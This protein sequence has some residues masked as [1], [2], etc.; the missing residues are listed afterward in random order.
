MRKTLTNKANGKKSRPKTKLGIPD[1][2][3]SKPRSSGALVLPTR[4]A[5]TSTLSMSSSP[6]TVLNLDWPSIKQ[7][8]CV[9]GFTWRS[10]ALRPER[11]TCEWRPC[12]GWLTRRLPL[13]Y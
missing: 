11:S 13:D 6:G 12:G 3:H 8:F 2:E 9:I 7:W 5:D 1:L 4:G 10:A